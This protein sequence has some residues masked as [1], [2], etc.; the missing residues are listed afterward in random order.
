LSIEIEQ[1]AE[2]FFDDGNIPVENFRGQQL[3]FGRFTAGITNGTRSPTG[4]GDRLMAEQL[5]AA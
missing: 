3:S 2:L 1:A 5:K 4:N